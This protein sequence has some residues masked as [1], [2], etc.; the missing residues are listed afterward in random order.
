MSPTPGLDPYT[1]PDAQYVYKAQPA[2]SEIARYF[3]EAAAAYESAANDVAASGIGERE[4]IRRIL[5]TLRGAE[6]RGGIACRLAI[7]YAL[8]N[9]L[10]TQME[11]AHAL[12]T[13]RTFV[14]TRRH[15][16]LTAEELES[17]LSFEN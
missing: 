4:R 8:D 12:G 16:P 2:L 5:T 11:V 7:E 9:K 17:L 13:S 14:Y 15:N 6:A 10:M 1:D 3:R